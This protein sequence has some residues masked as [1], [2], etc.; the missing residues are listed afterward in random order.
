MSLHYYSMVILHDY[1]LTILSTYY[2][3]ILQYY[4]IIICEYRRNTILPTFYM[5]ED[6]GG[7]LRHSLH[8]SL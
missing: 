1:H 6:H 5:R 7:L 3:M 2:L 8:A 4:N